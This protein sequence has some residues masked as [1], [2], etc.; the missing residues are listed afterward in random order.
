MGR[1]TTGRDKPVPYGKRLS[2][3]NGTGRVAEGS[4]PPPAPAD[5]DVPNSDIRLLGPWYRYAARA[6]ASRR[7]R[8]FSASC[9]TCVE[10]AAGAVSRPS[11]RPTVHDPVRRFPPPGPRG[12]GSPTF[13]LLSADSDFSPPVPARPAALRSPSLGGTTVCP[14][15]SRGLGPRPRA[16][17]SGPTGRSTSAVSWRRPRRA[18]DAGSAA[19]ARGAGLRSAAARYSCCGRCIGDRRRRSCA[20]PAPGGFAPACRRR[21]RPAA[22]P[23]GPPPSRRIQSPRRPRTVGPLKNML[24][25]PIGRRIGPS[26]FA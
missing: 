13:T 20:P 6:P 24:H 9:R 11:V 18:S 7:F 23:C 17:G 22:P 14:V 2:V 26:S 10:T 19:A 21:S 12:A 5:P 15:R 4:C 1:W 3:D 25:H 16:G 8:R